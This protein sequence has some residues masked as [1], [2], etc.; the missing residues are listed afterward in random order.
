MPT[1]AADVVEVLHLLNAVGASPRLSGGWGVDALH[2]QQTREH[3]DVDLAVDAGRLDA[4]VETLQRNGFVVTT[5]WLPVR[6]ELSD[7]GGGRHVDL[8]PLH[9]AADGSAWQAG[10]DGSRFDYPAD[11]WCAGSVGGME[12]RCLSARMQRA[13]HAG[14]ELRDVDRHDLRL[15]EDASAPGG[16]AP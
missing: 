6:V 11:A 10:L 2:G 9:S 7:P 8:H 5:D 16:Q 14:Y 12:V 4:C 15:L 1:T 3:R 13:F